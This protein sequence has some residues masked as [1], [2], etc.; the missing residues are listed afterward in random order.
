MLVCDH[1]SVGILV[2]RGLDILLIERRNPP[3]AFAPPA[4]HID[5][6]GSFEA[7][8]SIELLEEVGLV[9]KR[10]TLIGE[11]RKENPCRRTGGTWHYWKIFEAE[12][13]GEIRLS[14]RETRGAIWASPKTVRQLIA[15]TEEYS[16]NLIDDREWMARPGLEHVWIE[17]FR[18][19]NIV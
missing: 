18:D 14:P 6:H 17:W 9:A 4:G 16:R 11:G 15:R 5:Q 13:A 2:R 8:A 12:V 7:A 19:L 3:V 1:T 10:L